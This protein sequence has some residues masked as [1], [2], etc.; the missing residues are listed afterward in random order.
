MK[1]VPYLIP[2]TKVKSKQ[3]KDLNVSANTIK[4]LEE[5]IRI[6]IHDH[7]FNNGFLKMKL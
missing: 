4:L 2:Y 3:I 5:N 7:G 1:L 6:N